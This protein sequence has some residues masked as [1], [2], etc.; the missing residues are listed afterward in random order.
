MW[1]FDEVQNIVW[2]EPWAATSPGLEAEL[3]R[4]VGKRHPLFGREAVAV[5]RRFD[6]DDVL[7]YLPNSSPPLAVVHLTWRR[8]V[9]TEFPWTIFYRC[10]QDWVERCMKPDHDEWKQ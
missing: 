5:G 3:K 2:L 8:E 4:E 7:F 1:S 6:C 10:V 9:S